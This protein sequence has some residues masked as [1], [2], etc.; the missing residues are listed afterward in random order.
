VYSGILFK[1]VWVLKAKEPQKVNSTVGVT[2]MTVTPAPQNNTTPHKW[3]SIGWEFAVWI[4]FS[5][6]AVIFTY[7]L[8]LNLGS[9]L[10][11]GVGDNYAANWASWWVG[12]SITSGHNPFH[13]SLVFFPDGAHLNGEPL[14]F[15]IARGL[16]SIFLPSITAYNLLLLFQYPFA[17]WGAYRLALY[18]WRNRLGA[19]LAG[20]AFGFGSYM[21]LKGLGHL[22]FLNTGWI[23]LAVLACFRLLETE[24]LQWNRVII[25]GF[26][27]GMVGLSSSYFTIFIGIWVVGLAL[28][29]WRQGHRGHLYRLFLAGVV[30][31]LVILPQV[32]GMVAASGQGYY[33][34]GGMMGQSYLSSVDLLG[35]LLSLGYIRCLVSGQSYILAQSVRLILNALLI[36]V[37]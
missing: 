18:L 22:S 8:I 33:R 2:G 31:F 29:Q 24:N 14:P 21:M 34:S 26:L 28:F 25:A 4:G 19:L 9:Q 37:W 32:W 23:P 11:G 30:M 15:G 12:K 27:L 5:T 6:L 20:V 13:C 35:V 10:L 17:A 3:K 36:W 7:P 1:G 16:L